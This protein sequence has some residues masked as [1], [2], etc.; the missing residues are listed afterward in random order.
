MRKILCIV[1]LSLAACGS[2]AA[3]TQSPI[4]INCGGPA[5]TDSKGQAW[6]ADFGFNW[7]NVSSIAAVV[8]GSADQALFQN[9][10]YN[11]NFSVGMI[12]AFAVPNGQYHVN[13]YFA[14]TYGPTQAKGARV[15]NVKMQGN[16]VFTNLDVFAEAGANA[17]LLKGA[18]ITVANSQISIEFDNVVQTAKVDAIEIIPG[19]YGPPLTLNFQYPDGTPVAGSLVYSV[20]SSSLSFQGS[21]PLLNGRVQC[22]LLSN[23]SALGVSAQFQVTLSL[24]DSAGNILWM[25]SLGMNPAQVNLSTIQSSVLNVIVQKM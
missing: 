16:P 18:D 7:G 19:G 10:R 12:Y 4:R 22:Y 20:S 21:Q 8:A 23:P 24:K 15:F 25:M 17:A 3:Q 1:A 13:L 9:A 11:P 5:Y 6:Q 14:E 2:A